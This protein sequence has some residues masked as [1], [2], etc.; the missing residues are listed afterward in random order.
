MYLRI[1]LD[2]PRDPKAFALLVR[3]LLAVIVVYNRALLRGGL[4]RL[5]ETNTQYKE[6]KPG[7]DSFVDAATVVRRG[8]GDCAHLGAFRVA[9][10]LEDG[11]KA[12]LRIKWGVQRRNK[13]RPF[14]VEVRRED[15]TIE[16]PSRILGMGK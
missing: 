6:E 16:D 12:S 14:H 5:Y 13:P 11:E 9:E 2:G 4:Q 8:H 15:G 10:L 1:Q 3:G 7:E